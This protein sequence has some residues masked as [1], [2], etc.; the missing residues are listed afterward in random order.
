MAFTYIVLHCLGHVVVDPKIRSRQFWELNVGLDSGFCAGRH[1]ASL[2][3]PRSRYGEMTELEVMARYL[4][5]EE[6]S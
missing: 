1:V 6:P 3:C 4:I 2:I 5:T